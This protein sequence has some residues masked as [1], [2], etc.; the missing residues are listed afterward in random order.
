MNSNNSNVNGWAGYD[1]GSMYNFCQNRVLPGLPQ[2]LQLLIKQVKVPATA[3]DKLTTIANTDSYVY[4]PSYNEMFGSGSEGRLIPWL[5]N[6]ARWAPKRLYFYDII[7]PS[8]AL[9]SS[10]A[11]K[12]TTAYSTANEPVLGA[13]KGL[14]DADTNPD[15]VREGDIWQANNTTGYIFVSADTIRKNNM[16]VDLKVY[17]DGVVYGGWKVA[18]ITWLRSP[19][20]NSTYGFSSVSTYGAANG[21]SGNAN[22]SYGV[23][24]CF[25]I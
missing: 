5:P 12:Y 20:I 8:T 11:A 6:D 9:T 23:L 1:A 15:G 10:G 7:V 13:G 22:F 24:P 2:E 21:G 25:T 14:Y 16:S 17:L 19:H 4:I 18:A 3:G